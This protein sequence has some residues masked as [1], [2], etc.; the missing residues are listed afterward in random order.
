MK[1][2][3]AVKR[4]VDYNVKVRVKADGSDVDIGNV[5]MSMNPFDEIA[6][7]EAV[8]LKEA[9]KVSEIVAVSLGGK[10][11]EDTLRTALAMGADRAIHVETEAALEPLAVAKLL[12]AV[13]DKEQPQILLLGKQAIDDDANQTAQMLAAL[14][15]APQGT[16]VGKL[17][18][19]GSEAVVTRE[20]DGGMETVALK[21][22]A[23]ISADLRLNEPRYVK[24]PQI[25][26][27]KKNR[28][29]NPRPKNWV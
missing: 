10:K 14:M 28:W 2:L 8:R 25:M 26:Q 1:A 22:P 29:K 18:I 6:V 9:G 19:D 27:A 20:I 13:A 3:V 21:L 11:C 23:V 24:L 16:F 17:E 5:K 7:E 4:V 12:K 15:N